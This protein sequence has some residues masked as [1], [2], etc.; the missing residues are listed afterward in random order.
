MANTKKFRLTTS[1]NGVPDT[2][3]KL[4]A[5]IR[6]RLRYNSR[7]V[8]NQR[9][10]KD[11][12]PLLKPIHH[13]AS[14][15]GRIVSRVKAA[16]PEVYEAVYAQVKHEQSSKNVS[17]SK[18]RI[19]NKRRPE[20]VMPQLEKIADEVD[21][22]ELDIAKKELAQRALARKYLVASI[23]RFNPEYLAGW[24]HKDICRRL[25]KFMQD[26]EDGKN[27]RLLL[28]MPPRHGKSTI[29]SIEFPAWMLGHHPEWEVIVCSY[30]ETLA[31]DFSRAVRTRVRDKEYKALF[32]DTKL[33]RDNQNAK[34]WKTTKKGMFLP[35][36][37]EG[38]IT[39]K[40]AH[41]L[42]IDDPIKN[43]QEAESE[44]KRTGIMRWYSTTAYTRLAPGGGVL[45][46]QTRWHLDDLSGRLEMDML[47][48]KGDEFEVVRYPA[49]AVRDEKHRKRGAP[50]H[51][52]RYDINQ[53][54]MIR[55]A[56][57]ERTWAALY[58]QNPVPDEGAQFQKS[59]I[60]YYQ[61]DELPEK[62]TKV[63]AWDLAIGQ[64]E[65]NDKTVGFTWGRDI[66]GDYW[67]ID[68]RHGHFEAFEIIDEICD[69]FV[70][71]NPYTIGIEKDKVSMAMG[72]LL[73]IAIEERGLSSLHITELRPMLEGNK[74][75]RARTL[76]GLMRQGKVHF[77]YPDDAEWVDEFITELLQFPYGRR[78]DH[79]D[80]AAWLALMSSET[81]APDLNYSRLAPRK[82]WRDRLRGF[83]REQK[84]MMSS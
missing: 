20:V 1:A 32:P 39:G 57:G 71:H 28:Q 37:V 80:A 45:V 58:Q 23:L 67:F 50:L 5:A 62:L 47:E 22:E 84:S 12:R 24:V 35:A 11:G 18:L 2:V 34:G 46:I 72:P 43:S 6:A 21:A 77:P 31:L 60:K 76:Q 42:I 82:S 73:D 25:E 3:P 83:G 33:D 8:E 65:I 10:A 41:V 38:P 75:K 26:V 66:V 55:K 81:P 27:P 52:D 29:A 56:V 59:M 69:S 4:R 49:I 63:T 19:A 16:Q 17:K 79:V 54:K 64:K 30:A 44:L 15:F 48:G 68:C 74:V 40:G 9:R 13:S 53:L 36:G 70:Q 14:K 7:R 78:D 61:P 51:K